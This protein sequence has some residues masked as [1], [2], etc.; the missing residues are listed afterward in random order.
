MMIF[1][2]LFVPFSYFTDHIF[3]AA[4][5]ARSESREKCVDIEEV[6][7]PLHPVGTIVLASEDCGRMTPSTPSPATAPPPV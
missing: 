3:E 7:M 4:V 2:F 6:A 5:L 1:L